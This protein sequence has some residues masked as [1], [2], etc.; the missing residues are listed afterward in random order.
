[1]EKD[2]M[3]Y[4]GVV[5]GIIEEGDITKEYGIIEADIPGVIKGIRAFPKRSELSEP[6]IGDT[7]L[8][9]NLDPILNSY[10]IYE[11]LKE[12]NF[13]GIR[14]AGKMVSI[15]PRAISLGVFDEEG[16]YDEDEM[17]EY[18]SFICVEDSGEITVKSRIT[19][20]ETGQLKDGASIYINEKGECIINSDHIKITGGELEVNGNTMLGDAADSFN[21]SANGPFCSP[22]NWTCP[23]LN[24]PH[25]VPKIK[26]RDNTPAPLY[27]E[28]LKPEQFYL[29]PEENA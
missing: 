11:K 4:L 18:K 25:V 19:D 22:L 28:S 9:L 26:L 21:P 15:T 7:V 29:E 3:Y 20:P 8:L 13:V 12:N 10:W 27:S 16:G 24:T 14:S 6:K 5:T 17:P 1:M 23:L 2:K